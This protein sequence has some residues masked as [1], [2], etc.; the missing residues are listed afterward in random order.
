M[1]KTREIQIRCSGC[2]KWSTSPI[3]LGD[4][5]TFDTSTLIGN[6]AQCPKCGAM[7]RCDKENMRVRFTDG[8]F[9]GTET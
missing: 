7:M 4:S 1:G 6:Q 3:N 8:G 2:S 5:Q 9:V